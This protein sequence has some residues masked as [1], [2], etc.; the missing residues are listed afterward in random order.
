MKYKYDLQI[1]NVNSYQIIP[2]INQNIFS[3][4]FPKIA[5]DKLIIDNNNAHL[6]E[7]DPDSADYIK[8]FESQLDDIFEKI[9]FL[10]N[11]EKYFCTYF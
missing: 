6:I 9:S 5:T 7:A 2:N 11:T 8:N 10:I 3:N 1:S 4:N